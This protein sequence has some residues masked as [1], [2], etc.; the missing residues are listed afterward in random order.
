[1]SIEAIQYVQEAEE[2]AGKL[3]TD[4]DAEVKRI[5]ELTEETMAD[6]QSRLSSKL[7]EYEKEQQKRYDQEIEHIKKQVD[8]EISAKAAELDHSAK[9][10]ETDVVNDIVK[11]VIHRYG[12]S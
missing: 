9:V 1:M 4:S 5:K 12:N 6:H 3:E 10:N 7:A 8:E 2:R 11:E